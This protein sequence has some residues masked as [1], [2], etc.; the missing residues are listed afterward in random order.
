MGYDQP[1]IH[2]MEHTALFVRSYSDDCEIEFTQEVENTN[3]EYF[4]DEYKFVVGMKCGY[5]LVV[6]MIIMYY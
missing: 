4:P 1:V 6:S 3:V 2:F 5:S